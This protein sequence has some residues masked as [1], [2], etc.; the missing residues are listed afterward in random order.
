MILYSIIIAGLTSLTGAQ[1][2][3]SGSIFPLPAPEIRTPDSIEGILKTRRSVRDFSADSL[4]LA[5]VGRLL[6]AAQGVTHPEG[7]RTAPSAGA[8]Y[9][10]EVY[11]VAG[12]VETLRAG[13]YRYLPGKHALERIKSA[14]LRT[15]LCG[16]ALEQSWIAQAP[17]AVV[18]T[19]VYQRVTKKYGERGVRYA[20]LEAGAAAQNIYLEAT[21]LGLGT[22]FVGAF[23]DDRVSGLL[24]IPAG[25]FPLAV[26]PVGK[27]R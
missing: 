24:G 10:L 21:A 14:D 11:L 27:P 15:E 1:D 5:A 6:W 9:P 4:T 7:L 8:L 20:H 16:A 12:E 13:L 2:D 17:A 18:I 3:P 23:D 19:A 22:T 25:E 26:M